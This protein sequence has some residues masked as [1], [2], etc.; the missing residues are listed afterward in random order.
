[1]ENNIFHKIIYKDYKIYIKELIKMN[2]KI[3]LQ[4]LIQNNMNVN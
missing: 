4:T 3:M 2:L 1:M